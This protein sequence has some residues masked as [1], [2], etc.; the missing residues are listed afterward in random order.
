MV[1]V[2]PGGGEL[3]EVLQGWGIEPHL[4]GCLKIPAVQFCSAV[5]QYSI[6]VQNM[7]TY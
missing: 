5:L 1:D 3:Q 4:K 2:H 6:A 7:W